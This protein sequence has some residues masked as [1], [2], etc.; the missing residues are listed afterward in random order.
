M[1][2][3]AVFGSVPFPYSLVKQ[4]IPLEST[5]VASAGTFSPLNPAQPYNVSLDYRHLPILFALTKRKQSYDFK[6]DNGNCDLNVFRWLYR[7]Q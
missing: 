1:S 5:K 2:Q 4:S 3:L 7:R 6:S